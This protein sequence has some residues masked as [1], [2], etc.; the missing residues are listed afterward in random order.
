MRRK[1]V[2]NKSLVIWFTGLSGS[3]K[4]TLANIL[5]EVLNIKNIKTII[6]DGDS[7]RHGLGSDL[8]FS[9]EDRSEN[10]RRVGEMLNLLSNSDIIFLTAFIS[11]YKKDRNFV[12]KLIGEE[13][14]IEVFCDCSLKKCEERDVKGLYEKARA[15]LIKEFTG[16]SDIYERPKSPNIHLKTDKM[17]IQDCIDKIMEYLLN[18]DLIYRLEK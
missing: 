6:L 2:R 1:I 5:Q 7:V 13:N 10:I 16:I 9:K 14:F 12:K 8:G 18:K 3:G 11:P 4:S 17:N 15:G